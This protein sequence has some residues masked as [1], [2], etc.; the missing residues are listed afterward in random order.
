MRLP[1][2]L[3]LVCSASAGFCQ[4][5]TIDEAVSRAQSASEAIR[6]RSLAVSRARLARQEAAAQAWPHVDL[7]ASGSYLVS[8]PGGYT[9]AAG[10][11]GNLKPL[12]GVSY[13]LPAQ[14]LVIGAQPYDYISVAATLSQ[15]LFTWG[16]IKN[17][18]DAAGLQVD[19]A[20]TDLVA[21][22]RDITRQVRRAYFSALLA[23]ESEKV[24]AELSVVAADIV[25]DRQTALD[26][27]TGT[28]E[29]VLEARSRKAQVDAQLV[30]ARQGNET[31]RETLGVLTGVDEST[32]QLASGFPA[33]M[34][35]LDEEK[36][37]DRA[38][39]ASTDV[40]SSRI[41][42]SQAQK[43][44][45]IEQGGDL[46]HP[47]VALGVSLSATGAENYL[48]INGSEPNSNA[49]TSW[50]W[51]LVLSL[52]VKMSAFDGMAAAARIGEAEQD[53]QAAG[54]ALAQAQKLARLAARQAIDAAL[55]ADADLTEKTAAEAYAAERLANAQAGFDSGMSSRSDLRAAQVLHGSAR[56]DL[57]L[58]QYTREEAL[59]DIEHL[60]GGAP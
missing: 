58:A 17:A 26:Q 20:G 29:A 27:G 45:A 40:A 54:Q 56:L 31:A 6:I 5:L 48:V 57:L 9:V 32:V 42:Q 53:V 11:L 39:A 47:D 4:A 37:R 23:R 34:P 43:K 59:A 10:S 19:A 25:A 14:D 24:L 51:D 8:P 18:I 60:T 50:T 38:Q 52:N 49:P 21:Q 13:P 1:A 12:V 36:L 22:Q 15:P 28:R 7:Q 2:V 35:A 46:L 33:S 44:L 55:R 16:K 3:L 41:R 30:Q